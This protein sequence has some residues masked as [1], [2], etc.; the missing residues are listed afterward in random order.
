ML[1][2]ATRW[3]LRVVCSGIRWNCQ[4]D[5]GH[6]QTAINPTPCPPT[7]TAVSPGLLGRMTAIPGPS[8]ALAAAVLPRLTT[9]QEV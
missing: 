9:W 6:F 4:R 3:T 1:S 8:L 2:R 5:G 7:A